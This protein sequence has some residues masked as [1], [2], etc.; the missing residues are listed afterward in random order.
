MLPP[1]HVQDG[2]PF[3]QPGF[4]VD[5]D[6]FIPDRE[7]RAAPFAD[8]RIDRMRIVMRTCENAPFVTAAFGLAEPSESKTVRLLAVTPQE[9]RRQRWRLFL[10]TLNQDLAVTFEAFFDDTLLPGALQRR[11]EGR[12]ACLARSGTRVMASRCR[13]RPWCQQCTSLIR[14]QG[15][16]RIQCRWRRNARSRLVD[17]RHILRVT[18]AGQQQYQNQARTRSLHTITR[19][20]PAARP[21][22]TA[23][24]TCPRAGENPT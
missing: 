23:P 22:D 8:A 18:A 20:P 7:L 2:R 12:T 10:L 14:A 11:D 5:E 15:P 9:R 17:S 3:D 19:Y 6:G 13:R 4:H 1:T 24:A 21:P 16:Q